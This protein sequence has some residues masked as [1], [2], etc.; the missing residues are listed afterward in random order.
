[1][2]F[3]V[4]IQKPE[5]W[6]FVIA[7]QGPIHFY[8]LQFFKSCDLPLTPLAPLALAQYLISGQQE[9]LARPPRVWARHSAR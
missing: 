4:V 1:M 3:V 6:S 7:K 8:E 9:A 5:Q 2:F